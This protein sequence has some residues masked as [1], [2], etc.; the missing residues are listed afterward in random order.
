MKTKIVFEFRDERAADRFDAWFSDGGGT[1]GYWNS[2]RL[3]LDENVD[4]VFDMYREQDGLQPSDGGFTVK[5]TRVECFDFG[6]DKIALVAERFY[7]SRGELPTQKDVELEIK[8]TVDMGILGKSEASPEI[9]EHVKSLYED[10]ENG[11]WR[12]K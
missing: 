3:H 9:K 11:V 6:F 8:A 1:D 2:V 7:K 5:K 4:P 10:F 12:S